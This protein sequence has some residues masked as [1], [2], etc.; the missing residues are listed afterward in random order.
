MEIGRCGKECLKSWGSTLLGCRPGLRPLVPLVVKCHLTLELNRGRMDGKRKESYV[1]L[2]TESVQPKV[3]A[4]LSE[5]LL[6]SPSFN[7]H[8]AM[9]TRTRAALD[10][11]G[12][13][14]NSWQDVYWPSIWI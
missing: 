6:E 5:M 9:R 10:P 2:S 12:I 1:P 4:L 7:P 13:Y 3:C 14:N 11:S 8:A